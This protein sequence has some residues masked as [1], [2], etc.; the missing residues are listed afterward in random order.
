MVQCLNRSN[1]RWEL[2]F[3]HD[4]VFM[5]RAFYRH[6]SVVDR[7]KILT[8]GCIAVGLLAMVVDCGLGWHQSRR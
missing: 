1:R 5:V 8:I 2:T 6:Q 4:F 3:A 7:V